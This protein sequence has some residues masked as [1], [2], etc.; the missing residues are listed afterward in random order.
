MFGPVCEG[1]GAVGNAEYCVQS[2]V[3]SVA[4]SFPQNKLGF[5]STN[6][7]IGDSVALQSYCLSPSRITYSLFVAD[8]G[9]NRCTSSLLFSSYGPINPS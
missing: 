1:V 3:Y 8:S 5:G 6:C 2:S 4:R 7:L 9:E